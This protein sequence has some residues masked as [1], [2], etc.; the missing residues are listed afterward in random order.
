MVDVDLVDVDLVVVDLGTSV[1]TAAVVGAG[2][3][4]LLTSSCG[5]NSC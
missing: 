3:M 4:L 5:M 1:T 2:S